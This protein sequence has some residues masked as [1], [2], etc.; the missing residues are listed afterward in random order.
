[1]ACSHVCPGIRIHTID[2]VQ[3]P[4][5]GI[6][7]MADIGPHQRIVSA[8]LVAKSNAEIPAKTRWEVRLEAAP[9]SVLRQI[10][11]RY[12]RGA[13]LLAREAV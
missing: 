2:I 1:M 13:K 4:G 10:M 11:R 8:A 5:I 3:A 9:V 6:P 12:I 7:G